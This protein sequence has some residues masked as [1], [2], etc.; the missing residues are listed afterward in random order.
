MKYQKIISSILL[1]SA[2]AACS[3]LEEEI[4]AT[5]TA[6]T[7]HKDGNSNV[8]IR[9]S[10]GNS[11]TR[12][13]LNPIDDHGNFNADEIGIFML[14]TAGTGVNPK[15]YPILWRSYTDDADHAE[16][17][18]L[19]NV[20]AKA[21]YN[22]T[23]NITEIKW[24]KVEE[25]QW[26]IDEGAH[27]WYPFDNWYAYRFFGYS[28]YQGTVT[29]TDGIRSVTFGPEVLDGKHDIIYG[30]SDQA[31]GATGTVESLKYCAK[32]FRQTGS[33]TPNIHFEHKLMALQF[34]VYGLENI[35]GNFNDARKVGISRILIKDIPKTSA[36]LI[37]ADMNNPGNNGKITFNGGNWSTADGE[38]EITNEDGSDLFTRVPEAG[39]GGAVTVGSSIMLPVPPAGSSHKFRVYIELK[40]VNDLGVVD[41]NSITYDVKH[42]FD[43]NFSSFEEGKI[44][45]INIGIAGPQ[46]IKINATLNEWEEATD[47]PTHLEFN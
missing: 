22:T 8:E 15:A 13:M 45:D 39:V 14:A 2:F 16:P 18:V 6:P 17:V 42:P 46:E 33:A 34:K 35:D 30:Y 4:T 7:G 21:V 12:S 27:Y 31:S 25:N 26:K 20:R 43:L 24:A 38:I 37:I 3:Q 36:T 1:A 47:E 19:N 23:E 11:L 28:P 5:E 41:A 29:Q 44:F 32:Y 10:S 9:L 40:S